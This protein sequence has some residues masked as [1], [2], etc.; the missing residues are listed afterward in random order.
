MTKL[1]SQSVTMALALILTGT[2][3]KEADCSVSGSVLNLSMAL[4]RC[5]RTGELH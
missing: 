3:A 4:W 2:L 1:Q 5:T